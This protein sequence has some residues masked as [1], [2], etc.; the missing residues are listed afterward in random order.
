ECFVAENPLLRVPAEIHLKVC[1]RCGSYLLAHEWREA[2]GDPEESLLSAAEEAVLSR[3]KVVKVTPVGVNYVGPDE[4]KEIKIEVEPRFVP[5]DILVEVFAQGK[6]QGSQ[7][8]PLSQRA[9][10]KVKLKRTTCDVCS[11]V[12]SGYYEAILQVR[13]EGELPEERLARVRRTLEEGV[14][15]AHKRDR[16][17][18]VAKVERKH[19][20]LDFYLSSLALARQMARLLKS[21][22]GAEV[23][24]SAKL[25]GRDKSGRRKF[26]VSVL[27]RLPASR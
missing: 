3:L 23:Q 25:V 16:S 20:G 17:A 8:E 19:G 12:S 18:F 26:R 7:A 24:E 9:R 11:R 6:F 22:F 4:A 2:S 13:G 15:A 14:F 10:V 5:P 1:G 27:S 21:E